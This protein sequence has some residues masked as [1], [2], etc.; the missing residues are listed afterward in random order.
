M[1]GEKSIEN[2]LIFRRQFLISWKKI[3]QLDNWRCFDLG[4]VYLYSHPD[5]EVTIKRTPAE[6]I[7]LLGYIFN[8]FYPSQS[9]ENILAD[10]STKTKSFDE[11]SN[12]LKWYVGRYVLIYKNKNNFYILNDPL[13]LREIYYYAK[14]NKILCGS[15]PNLLSK[16]SDPKL[17][18]TCNEEILRFYKY[19]IKQVRFGRLWVGEDSYYEGVKHLLPNHY[20]DLNR[21][22]VQRYWPKGDLPKIDPSAALENSCKYLKGVMEAVITRYDVMMAVT[23]GIDSRSLLAASKDFSDRI[24]YFINKEPPL[25]DEHPDIRVP[26]EMFRYIGIPFHIHEIPT[27]VPEEFREI[28]LNNVFMATDRILPTIYNIY[29]QKLSNRVNLLGVGEIGRDYYGKAPKNLDGY[30]LAR[31]LKYKSSKYVTKKC[32]EWLEETYPVAKRYNIDIMRLFLWEILLGNWGVV[33]NSES[34]IAIEEFDPYDSHYIY[35]IML[36]LD[37]AKYNLQLEMIKA[38]W[39]ELLEFPFNPS[40]NM[41]DRVK[42]HLD[43]FGLLYFLKRQI[44]RF[45]RWRFIRVLQKQ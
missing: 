19:D 6:L 27:E 17:G 8:P 13:S 21:L 31:C 30:Y 16:F 1:N 33:G 26:R 28:F 4:D 9:N 14:P 22:T 35:E 3:K 34:D 23:S 38:M 7:V 29:F 43:R 5:L 32:E 42:K 40:K 11:I 2:P 20:L 10:L 44:Y 37:P 15:Q 36:S 18:I 41:K 39:P 45:D 12:A 24:Y 25:N